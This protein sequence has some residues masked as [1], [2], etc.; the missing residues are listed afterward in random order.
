VGK[1]GRQGFPLIDAN[2]RELNETGFISN[3]GRQNVV[4]FLAQNLN[5]DWRMGAEIFECFTTRL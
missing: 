5:I 4:S 2:M 1:R 3:R